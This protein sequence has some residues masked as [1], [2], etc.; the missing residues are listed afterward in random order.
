MCCK[1]VEISQKM[2][3]KCSKE[4]YKDS[5]SEGEEDLFEV[6]GALE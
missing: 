4:M 3:E 5:A 6:L 2:I 1:D